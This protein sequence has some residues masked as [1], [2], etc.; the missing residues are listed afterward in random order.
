MRR[1]SFFRSSWASLDVR[2]FASAVVG[3]RQRVSR[4]ESGVEKIRSSVV[5]YGFP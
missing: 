2:A 4:S 5:K 1:V 3:C